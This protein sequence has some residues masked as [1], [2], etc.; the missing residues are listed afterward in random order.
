MKQWLKKN[1]ST[2]ER[3]IQVARVKKAFGCST[4]ITSHR[5]GYTVS[6]LPPKF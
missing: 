4:V 5:T 1:V 2:L 6:W 3:A